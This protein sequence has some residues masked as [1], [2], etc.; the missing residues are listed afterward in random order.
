MDTDSERRNV[1]AE[2]VGERIMSWAASGA[3][4]GGLALGFYLLNER[5]KMIEETKESRT[6]SCRSCSA[7]II[8]MKTTNFKRIPVDYDS[9]KGMELM[10]EPGT[11]V[12][13]FATC[14]NASKH[15]KRR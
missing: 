7:P 11:H 5:K 3:A 10:F 12:S 6:R 8:W 15:R 13:H 1:H 9:V 4:A 2:I 14:P